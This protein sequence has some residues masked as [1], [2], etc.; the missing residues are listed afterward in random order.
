M[1]WLSHC[2]SIQL[3]DFPLLTNDSLD[4]RS[5]QRCKAQV[6]DLNKTCGAVD[7]D[8][9]TLEISMDDGGCA[10]VEEVEASQDLPTPAADHF[11]LDCF[12]AAHVAEGWERE[13]EGGG[14]GEK[15]GGKEKG[16]EGE[17]EVTYHNT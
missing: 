12:Q 1:C 11:M 4:I 10:G 2:V 16:R 7:E 17:R 9:V 8:V 13:R 3:V 14:K 5:F 15:E 6:A